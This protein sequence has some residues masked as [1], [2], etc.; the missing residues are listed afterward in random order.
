M[1][2]R[3]HSRRD[4]GAQIMLWGVSLLVALSMVFGYLL[5]GMTPPTPT[6]P[7]DDFPTVVFPTDTP[8]PTPTVAAT[9][10]PPAPR[11]PTPTASPTP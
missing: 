4:R 2:K 1:A 11:P 5:S 10:V 8:R 6:V 3:G 9:I 7:V